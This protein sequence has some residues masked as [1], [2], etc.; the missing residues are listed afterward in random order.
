MP[1]KLS[2]RNTYRSVSDGNKKKL[3]QYTSS[4]KQRDENK[5]LLVLQQFQSLK[6]ETR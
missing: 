6:Y 2:L 5:F 4:N 3:D 1:T